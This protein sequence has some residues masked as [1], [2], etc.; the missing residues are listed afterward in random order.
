MILCHC[1]TVELRHC[2]TVVLLNYGTVVLLN[3]GTVVPSNYSTVVLLYYGTVWHPMQ[4]TAVVYLSLSNVVLLH[5][6]LVKRNFSA[7]FL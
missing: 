5:C 6:C 2:G 7:V 1:G 3:Y 4:L